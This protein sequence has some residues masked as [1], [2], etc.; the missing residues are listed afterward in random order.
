MKVL[1]YNWQQSFHWTRWH[2][3]YSIL[4]HGLKDNTDSKNLPGVHSCKRGLR[5][6][7]YPCYT[8]MPD[9]VCYSI[10][11]ELDIVDIRPLTHRLGNQELATREE[12][13]RV[14]AVWTSALTMEKL[15]E[16]TQQ[17]IVVALLGM[18]EPSSE[19][20]RPSVCT[21]LEEHM[22]EQP[23]PDAWIV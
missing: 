19:T 3:I 10:C 17:E 5:G 15:H 2:Y 16:L 14:A 21:P 20:F 4:L 9:G 12:Y 18:W 13:V 8:H 1:L 23:F 22:G 11:C 6:T 7:T